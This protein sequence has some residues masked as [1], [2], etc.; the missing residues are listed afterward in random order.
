MQRGCALARTRVDLAMLH[1]CICHDVQEGIEECMTN[2]MLQQWS[3]RTK[4]AI[5]PLL[6][7]NAIRAEG[8]RWGKKIAVDKTCM[9]T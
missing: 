1:V 2:T 4:A 5:T 6:L 8:V 7:W 3:N 9:K